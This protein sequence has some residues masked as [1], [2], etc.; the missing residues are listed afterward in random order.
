M[1]FKPIF[2]DPTGRR[3]RLLL[4]LA[5]GLGTI[6]G[7]VMA[8]FVATLVTVQSTAIA[9]NPASHTSLRCAWSPNC[10]PTHALRA[11]AVADPE[12][13][14]AAAKLAAQL[15][16]QERK[17]HRPPQARVVDRRSVPA[18]LASPK[19][20]PLTIGFYVD[21]DDNSYPA[22][23]R[24]L[25]SLDWVVP[26]WLSL[27]GSD[28]ALKTNVDARVLNYIESTKPAVAI[29]PMIQNV[30][31]D[32]WDGRGLA[33]L[34]ADPAARAARIAQIVDF[35]GQYK[36]QGL[37]VDFEEVPLSAQKNLKLFLTELGAAFAA[38]DY[39]LVLSVPFDDD[40]W[41]YT[42]YADI[43]DYMLLM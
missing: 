35:L 11:T 1:S 29:L 31:N 33:K 32:E 10:T 4:R 2:F 8:L 41:P 5:W 13:L 6:S 28:M 38:H 43:V 19:D 30:V 26:S 39:A 37:V 16:E 36:F 42:T 21:W 22:L 14:S 3:S 12:K 17:L 18:S 15:R 27:E 24:A 40:N 34:L 20:R 9:Q 23:K 25:P 7:L